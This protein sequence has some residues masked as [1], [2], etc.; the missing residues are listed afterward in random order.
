M[1]RRWLLAAAVLLLAACSAPTDVTDAAGTAA[2]VDGGPAGPSPALE[3]ALV[4]GLPPCPPTTKGPAVPDGLPDLVLECLGPGGPVAMSGLRGPL[5]LN[6]WASWCPPCRAELPALAEFAE[7]IGPGV[8]VLGLNVSD[9]P[10]PA[11]ALW[12]ED[13]MPFPSVVDPQAATRPGLRWVGLPVTYFI[14][15]A[16]RVVGRH[17]GAITSPEGWK[18]AYERHLGQP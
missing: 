12:R 2:P 15:E 8:S 17:D 11:A 7:Q 6:T 4:A 9:S 10:A 13:A 18:Q 16:G 3:A 14:D 5:V 1:S